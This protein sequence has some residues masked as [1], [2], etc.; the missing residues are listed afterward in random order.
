MILV[1]VRQ[2]ESGEVIAVFFEEIKVRDRDVDTIRRL[3]GKTHAGIDDDHL[4]AVADTHAVHPEF[5]DT[6]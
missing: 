2:H 4:I 1:S 5:A 6:A 3:L